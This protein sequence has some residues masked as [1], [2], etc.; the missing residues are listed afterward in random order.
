MAQSGPAPPPP[1]NVDRT[2]MAGG[3][4]LPSHRPSRLA[5]R[6]QL[7]PARRLARLPCAIQNLGALQA[8]AEGALYTLSMGLARRQSHTGRQLPIHRGEGEGLL[9]EADA[10]TPERVGACS[11]S[12]SLFPYKMLSSMLNNQSCVQ[13]KLC[14]KREKHSDNPEDPKADDTVLLMAR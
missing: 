1:E 2:A 5:E 11:P 13:L 14:A 8:I 10:P 7:Q 6:M 9:L 4:I 12:S 3:E